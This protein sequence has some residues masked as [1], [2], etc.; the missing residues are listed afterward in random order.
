MRRGYS[1]PTASVFKA[2][3]SACFAATDKGG[4][5]LCLV[6]NRSEDPTWNGP[7]AIRPSYGKD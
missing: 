4:L 2:K 5:L 3:W 6:G 1:G 7:M